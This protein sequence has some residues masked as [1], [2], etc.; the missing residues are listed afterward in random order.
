MVPMVSTVSVLG[1]RIFFGENL[2]LRSITAKH[3]LISKRQRVFCIEACAIG[4]YRPVLLLVTDSFQ[5]YELNSSESGGIGS[6]RVPERRIICI[7]LSRQ[8]QKLKQQQLKRRMKLLFESLIA[9]FT[10]RPS[11]PQTI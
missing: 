7:M 3:M 5:K 6:D 11:E 1:N 8:I 4:Q 2:F 9:H 10:L